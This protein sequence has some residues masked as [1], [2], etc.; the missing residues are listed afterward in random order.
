MVA[1]VYIAQSLDGYIAGP[2]GEIDWLERGKDVT[3]RNF[4]YDAVG[5]AAIILVA[6]VTPIAAFAIANPM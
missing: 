4:G 5:A 1:F 2:N 6:G 3:I